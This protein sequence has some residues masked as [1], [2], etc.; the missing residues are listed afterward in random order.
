MGPK[1]G[2]LAAGPAR[3]S[4][5]G[6]RTEVRARPALTSRSEQN[7]SPE[8]ERRVRWEGESRGVVRARAGAAARAESCL[9]VGL[10]RCWNPTGR[11]AT[12]SWP[13]A[14]AVGSDSAWRGSADGLRVDRLSAWQVAALDGMGRK[15]WVS[16]R[17]AQAWT[18]VHASVSAHRIASFRPK[19]RGLFENY[20]ENRVT[21]VWQKARLETCATGCSELRG[22]GSRGLRV[23]CSR[24][25][26]RALWFRSRR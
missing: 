9:L 20:P 6:A 19:G 3:A 12:A 14:C 23:A 15:L 22:R 8:R 7:Q 5:R 10:A 18:S 25:T 1:T 17:P 24:A 2:R 26:S 4:A 13:V 16:R 11:D 21:Q